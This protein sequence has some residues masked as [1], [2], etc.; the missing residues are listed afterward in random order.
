ME[1][2]I[3]A[4]ERVAAAMLQGKELRGERARRGLDQARQIKMIGAEADAKFP[5]RGA[6]L[7]GE[8]FHVV[9]D[10]RAIENAERFGDLESNAARNALEP[11]AFLQIR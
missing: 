10:A 8:A 6:G 2:F 4:L 11:L 1:D 3:E 9:G 5:Q 7:L